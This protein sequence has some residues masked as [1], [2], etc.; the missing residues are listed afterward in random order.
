MQNGF[1]ARRQRAIS[2]AGRQRAVS[3][4]RRVKL[5]TMVQ[6]NWSMKPKRVSR[7]RGA[8]KTVSDKSVGRL[9]TG[10]FTKKY[11]KRTAVTRGVT[12]VYEFCGVLS[13]GATVG[14]VG[15]L[16]YIGHTMPLWTMLE[17]A[18]WSVIR[19]L[20]IKAG[21]SVAGAFP[22]TALSALD[23]RN[24]DVITVRY[25]NTGATALSSTSYT[26]VTTDT[27]NTIMNTFASNSNWATLTSGNSV[28]FFDIQY[29]PNV[30]ITSPTNRAV[31]K[32]DNCMLNFDV[33]SDLK[34]QNQT[35]FSS[36]DDT[37]EDVNNIPV[38]GKSYEGPGTGPS[39]IGYEAG[40]G[41][42]S[43]T[44]S[45]KGNLNTGFIQAVPSG[46]GATDAGMREP[47]EYQ[48][49][50]PIRKVGKIHLDASQLKT[51]VLEKKIKVQFNKFMNLVYP[52]TSEPSAT[53][54]GTR[55]INGNLS[56]YRMFG[57][58]K[59]LDSATVTTP[60]DTRTPVLIGFEVNNR[61]FCSAKP[62]VS[63]PTLIRFL[64]SYLN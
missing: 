32:L 1:R 50:K 53:A 51:S 62:K 46:N 54:V 19:L 13:S 38:Y 17:T 10:R 31:V 11:R 25:R 40:V 33:K 22:A 48:L 52:E 29:V 2:T 30:V 64:K 39:L 59:M 35:K 63:N 55:N 41:T 42:F 26:V 49:F 45:W 3:T 5:G 58:E 27:V 34:L 15:E 43:S 12:T 56:I 24:G 7:R 23:L 36:T 21:V 9:K 28:E 14:Q 6:T 44:L 37:S 47:L 4:A 57:I 8:V 18:W 61:I 60:G 16:V 20:L